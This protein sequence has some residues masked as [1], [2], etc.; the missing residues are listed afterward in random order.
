MFPDLIDQ[1]TIT[2]VE[3]S[4]NILSGFGADL[5]EYT[6][7]RFR[8][9][10]IRVMT[11]SAVVK[12][13]ADCVELADGYRMRYGVLVW[14]TGIMMNP[15]TASLGWHKGAGLGRI[16]VDEFLRP[17]HPALPNV[18]CIGDCA[19]NN[20]LPPTAQVA[21]QEGKY[22]AKMLNAMLSAPMDEFDERY[23]AYDRPFRYVF[24]G[25]MAYVGGWKAVTSLPGHASAHTAVG[26]WMTKLQGF[27]AFV[28]WRGAYL[29]MLVSTSNKVLI[30]M[31]WF[32]SWAFG[33]DFSRF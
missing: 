20:G 25:T 18:F 2:L 32:K 28:A 17:S 4:S 15:L 24:R 30:P 27:K 1:V 11:N 9:R 5:A 23:A 10:R 8:K 14:A 21:R 33:R 29:T 6:I 22:V 19:N 7:T 31:Y 16:E 26:K 12:V 13:D 3:A